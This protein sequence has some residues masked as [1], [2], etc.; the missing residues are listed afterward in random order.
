MQGDAGAEAKHGIFVLIWNCSTEHFQ[1]N[2]QALAP[3]GAL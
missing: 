1:V 2:T 3:S